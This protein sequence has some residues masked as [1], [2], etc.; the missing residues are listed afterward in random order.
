M[1]VTLTPK[2]FNGDCDLLQAN[3][4]VALVTEHLIV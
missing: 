1:F 2:V 4:P 3:T